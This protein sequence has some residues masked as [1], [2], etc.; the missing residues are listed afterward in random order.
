MVPNEP[1]FI[2][3]PLLVYR[4]LFLFAVVNLSSFALELEL[5]LDARKRPAVQRKMDAKSVPCTD[6]FPFQ[7]LTLR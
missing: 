7:Q 4:I 1:N 2:P 6:A 5:S 3:S